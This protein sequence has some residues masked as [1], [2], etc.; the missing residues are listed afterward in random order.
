MGRTQ[1]HEGLCGFGVGGVQAETSSEG[2]SEV[3]SRC[4]AEFLG[5]AKFKSLRR[6]TIETKLNKPCPLAGDAYF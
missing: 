3:A 1:E 2:R 4:H 6:M 5:S